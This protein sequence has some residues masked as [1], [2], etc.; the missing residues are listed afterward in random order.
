MISGLLNTNERMFA[1]VARALS[2]P[3]LAENNLGIICPFGGVMSVKTD[4]KSLWLE[5]EIKLFIR[6]QNKNR[7]QKHDTFE[8]N[9]LLVLGDM[10]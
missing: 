3:T 7:N 9:L 4:T 1:A 6:D 8:T 2:Y 5:D 10:F